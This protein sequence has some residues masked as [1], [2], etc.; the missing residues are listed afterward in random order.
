MADAMECELSDGTPFFEA[1]GLQPEEAERIILADRDATI[2]LE[3]AAIAGSNHHKAA[4]LDQRYTRHPWLRPMGRL[5]RFDAI[6][7]ILGKDPR[8][9]SPTGTVQSRHEH[10]APPPEG[11][12]VPR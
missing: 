6:R 8:V 11:S 12:P 10:D 3:A 4:V 9:H 5:I 1:L 7:K 2:R